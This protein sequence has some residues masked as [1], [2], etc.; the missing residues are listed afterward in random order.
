MDN[1]RFQLGPFIME[2]HNFPQLWVKHAQESF[3]PAPPNSDEPIL[4]VHLRKEGTADRGDG[5]GFLVDLDH[6]QVK[7]MLNGWT[8]FHERVFSAHYQQNLERIDLEVKCNQNEPRLILDNVLRGVVSAMLPLRFNGL[9]LHASSGLLNDEGI[10]FAGLST[11]GKTTM[12]EGMQKAKF[13]SDDISLVRNLSTAPELMAS[14]FFGALG[15]RGADED[16]PLRAVALLEKDEK[17]TRITPVGKQQACIE[18]MRHVVCFAHDAK[19]K[20]AIFSRVLELVERVPV[21]RVA[22]FIETP[23]DEICQ[24][25]LDMAKAQKNNIAK[26]AN[27]SS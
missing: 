22:R 26:Q 20:D 8:V 25:L 17:E 21:F 6:I 7:P 16:G 3:A 18:L 10:F 24:Q 9:M 11:A 27:P 2:T 1:L 15:R 5:S 14:P 23:S 12:A 19:L 13:L 4:H